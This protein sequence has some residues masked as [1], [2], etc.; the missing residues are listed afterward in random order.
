MDYV[1]SI[2]NAV[3]GT[4]SDSSLVLVFVIVWVLASTYL[5]SPTAC[6]RVHMCACTSACASAQTLAHD[7]ACVRRFLWSLG[8]SCARA[9][10]CLYACMSVFVLHARTCERSCVATCKSFSLVKGPSRVAV[11]HRRSLRRGR[12]R[13]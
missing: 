10:Y 11:R 12:A 8:S 5:R 6:A 7:G 2:V 13:A 1:R 4:R 9:R 3:L